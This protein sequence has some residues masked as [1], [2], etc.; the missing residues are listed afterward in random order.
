MQ[1]GY[2]IW[3]ARVSRKYSRKLVNKF[4]LIMTHNVYLELDHML[5]NSVKL[6]NEISIS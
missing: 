4:F 5:L 1:F 3:S 6:N 2:N